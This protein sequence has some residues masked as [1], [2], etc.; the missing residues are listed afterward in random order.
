M[1]TDENLKTMLKEAID[2]IEKMSIEEL[3]QEFKDFGIDVIKK[4]KNI[5]I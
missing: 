1:I 4:E 2:S 5:D 3:E